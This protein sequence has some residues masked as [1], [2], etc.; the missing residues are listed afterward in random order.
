[1]KNINIS[2]SEWK[3]AL[4]DAI[5]QDDGY[6]I[7]EIAEELGF[8]RGKTARLINKKVME[9]EAIKGKALRID[10]CGRSYVVSVYK[11]KKEK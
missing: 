2:L 4:H 8:S 10:E 9:G 11:L 3:E 6:T 5:H 7:S 1:M